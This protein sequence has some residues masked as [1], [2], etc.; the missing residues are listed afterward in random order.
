MAVIL[1][2]VVSNLWRISLNKYLNR[3]RYSKFLRIEGKPFDFNQTRVQSMQ[4]DIILRARTACRNVLNLKVGT[5]VI[6]FSV[7]PEN[8]HPNK[9]SKQKGEMTLWQEFDRFSFFI[10]HQVRKSVPTEI[11]MELSTD[12]FWIRNAALISI[13]KFQPYSY[14][15]NWVTELENEH[16]LPKFSS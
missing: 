6:D 1:Y 9:V 2:P 12:L 16:L 8:H 7:L 13:Y 11:D 4:S 10:F 3:K 5:N 14:V 15:C